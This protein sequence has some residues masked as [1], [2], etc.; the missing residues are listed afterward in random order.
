[1]SAISVDKLRYA[2][3]VPASL[4]LLYPEYMGWGMPGLIKLALSRQ[5]KTWSPHVGGLQISYREWD[6]ARSSRNAGRVFSMW[7]QSAAALLDEC[8]ARERYMRGAIAANGGVFPRWDD[9]GEA[10]QALFK[11]RWFYERDSLTRDFTTSELGR[12]RYRPPVPAEFLGYGPR[13]GQGLALCADLHAGKARALIRLFLATALPGMFLS[14]AWGGARFWAEGPEGPGVGYCAL[15][16]TLR[17]VLKDIGGWAKRNGDGFEGW[18]SLVSLL[19]VGG[20]VEAPPA[21]EFLTQVE[22]W[23]GEEVEE[24]GTNL[25]GWRAHYDHGVDMFCQNAALVPPTRTYREFVDSWDWAREGASDVGSKVWISVHGYKK[26]IPLRRTKDLA[27]LALRPEE[28]WR[29]A[30]DPIPK[31]ARAMVKCETG[32]ARAV[33]VSDMTLYLRMAWLSETL[34][35]VLRSTQGTSLFFRGSRYSQLWME[36][37]A[38]AGEAG[39]WKLPIDQSEFDHHVSL[40]MIDVVLRRMERL[41]STQEQK[42][43]LQAIRVA[44]TLQPA[45]VAVGDH[46]VPAKKGIQSGWR[47]TALLDT[48]VQFAE[49]YA[50][51]AWIAQSMGNFRFRLSGLYTQGDDARF[52]TYSPGFGIA[53]CE[54]MRAAGFDINPSKTWLSPFRDEYLRQ[55]STPSTGTHGYLNRAVSSILWRNPIKE[56]LIDPATAIATAV[57]RWDTVRARGADLASAAIHAK[58]EVV[59]LIT[60][61]GLPQDKVFSWLHGPKPLGGL[62]THTL[63][64]HP[65]DYSRLARGYWS[66]VV[67]KTTR[68]CKLPSLP[69][70][71]RVKSYGPLYGLDVNT[72]GALL[73]QEAVTRMRPFMPG[74]TNDRDKQTI[75]W[76]SQGRVMPAMLTSGPRLGDVPLRVPMIKDGCPNWVRQAAIKRLLE[77]RRYAEIDALILEGYRGLSRW[78]RNVHRLRTWIDWIQGGLTLPLRTWDTWGSGYLS[79][80]YKSMERRFLRNCLSQSTS[81]SGPYRLRLEMGYYLLQRDPASFSACKVGA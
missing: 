41:L 24:P 45:G 14:E 40:S 64:M 56:D 67:H 19:D 28:L 52:V 68:A 79:G 46:V 15:E 37:A 74:V 5:H 13:Y 77:E 9:I 71:E 47:W 34:E 32:K 12:R 1:M 17:S 62:A 27:S 18:E 25:P 3:Y 6:L 50:S 23:V 55:V 4:P 58:R 80:L 26:P 69:G 66:P 30:C 22:H 78:V 36:M 43:V 60:R 10:G 2:M 38:S 65:E 57:A 7:T 73:Y 59:H 51:W 70:L 63:G 11:S 33:L 31:P 53:L 54:V 29:I 61:H 72:F 44:V 81:Y 42:D 20:Y 8:S 75:T 49:V 48:W 21:E 35:Y 76:R 39:L 16:S